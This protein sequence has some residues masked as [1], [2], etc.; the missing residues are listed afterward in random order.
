MAKAKQFCVIPTWNTLRRSFEHD[1][2]KGRVE[3]GR[4]M[5][6]SIVLIAKNRRVGQ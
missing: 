2:F 6:M 3:R 1:M 4:L 5:D